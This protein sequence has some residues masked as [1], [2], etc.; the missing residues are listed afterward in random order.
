MSEFLIINFGVQ[1]HL[2]SQIYQKNFIRQG[3]ELISIKSHVVLVV[4]HVNK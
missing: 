4:K 2:K 3:I 1:F